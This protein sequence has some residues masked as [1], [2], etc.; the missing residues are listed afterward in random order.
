M[1]TPRDPLALLP[2]TPAMFHVLVALADGETHGYEIM[3]EVERLTNGAVRLSTGTLYGIIKRLLADGLI[4]ETA[5]GGDAR[6]RRYQ[7]TRFGRDVARAES[8]RSSRRWRWPSGKRCSEREPVASGSDLPQ[9]PAPS[10]PNSR[11]LRRR[12]GADIPRSPAGHARSGRH[13]GTSGVLA[14]HH[15]RH[16]DDGRASIS[17]CSGRT[18]AWLPHAPSQSRRRVAILALAVGIGANTAVFSIVN[19]VLFKPLPYA[20]PGRL[21]TMFEKVTGGP[22]KKFGFSPPDFEIVRRHATSFTGLAAYRNVSYELS[23]IGQSDRVTAA[24]VSPELFSVLGAH[25]ALGRT[26]TNEDDAANAPVAVL[27]AGLWASAFGRDPGVVGRTIALDRR[28]FTIVGV[29]PAPFAFP[30]R[31]SDL[32]GE[33]AAL[34]VPIAFS[35]FERRA[36]GNMYNNSVVGRLKPG[37]S[38][39]GARAEIVSL[40]KPLIDAYPPAIKG[41]AERLLIP[42]GPF[43]E[44]IVGESRRLLLLLMGAVGIVLLIGCADVANLMLT[45]AGSRQRELAIRAAIGASPGRVVRQLLTE[46]LVLAVLGAALGLLLAYGAMQAFLSLA[47][48]SLPRA[49]SIGFDWTVVVFTTILALITPLLFGVAP[50]LQAA[51]SS[52]VG[53]LKEG[54]HSTPGRARHRLL[55]ALVV[56]QFAL[57][58]MLSVG[59]GLLVRSFMR[60]L[61]TSP[62]FRTEHVINAATTLPTG[63]YSSGQMVKAFY[64]QA[65][66]S[67]RQIPGVTFAGASTDRPLRTRERRTFTADATARPVPVL[68]RVIAATWT[69]GS[70]FEALGIPLKRGRFFTDA[71]GKIG[72]PV[73]IINETL[74]KTLWPTE[75]PIGRQMKWGGDSSPAP[76]KTVVGVV[77]DVKQGPLASE[78]LPQTYEP[79]AQEVADRMPAFVLPFY[80]DVNVVVRTAGDSDAAAAAIRSTLRR[81]DPVLSP[82]K[83]EAVADIVRDS[84]QPQRFSMTVLALFAGV[85]LALA[86]IGIYGV[87]AN[88]VTQQTREIGLRM[89]LGASTN[90]VLSMVLSRAMGLMAVG[91]AIGM[92]GALALTRVMAGLLYEIRPNDAMTFFG[93]AFLLAGLAL[94]A[95]LIPAWR[96]TRVDPL[97]ALRAD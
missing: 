36:F 29:M 31:G 80:S 92:A 25:A 72:Q 60:L 45:R 79:L 44:E 81:S 50:A 77:G 67:A 37:V 71:D 8:A 4:K 64:E 21:V 39:E 93:S 94:V 5:L 48:E 13:H 68:N 42:F 2:L 3:K 55:G 41:M 12:D 66:D 75:D 16:R 74:A 56:A 11:R 22:I 85:A 40:S 32:N 35:P 62:G 6:R 52:T 73:T 49:E 90:D 1:P 15:S 46:S 59:A 88:A 18:C 28:P 47:G 26:L 19:G 58:L 34:F 76:W 87:L 82:A 65:V 54:S 95:S 57:A 63:R 97:V 51:M 83:T 17:I 7:L 70:Y 89:A 38:V 27:S 20:D 14:G 33:P 69:V 91:V 9:A 23:G 78:I 84:V 86:A 43:D 61:G 10:Q 53:S 24:R 30:P 96:A